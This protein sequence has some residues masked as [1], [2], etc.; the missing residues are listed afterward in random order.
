MKK[1]EKAFAIIFLAVVLFFMSSIVLRTFTRQVLVKRMEI[2]NGFTEAVLFDVSNLNNAVKS[3]VDEDGVVH[4]SGHRIID[5]AALYPFSNGIPRAKVTT[6]RSGTGKNMPS[7]VRLIEDSAEIYT[8]DFLIWY[9]KM[10]ELAQGYEKLLRWNYVPLSEYNGIVETSDGL[11]TTLTPKADVVDAAASLSTLNTF[12]Q[13]NGI[14]LLY[15]VAP[16]KICQYDDNDLSGIL[17]FANQNTNELLTVLDENSIN[18]LDLRESLHSEGIHHHDMFFITDHHWKPEAGL[19]ASRKIAEFLNTEY[20]YHFDLSLL[21]E[22]NIDVKVYQDWFL[23]SQGKKVTLSRANPEDISL[24]FPKYPT[25]F[26]YEIKSENIDENGDFSVFYNLESI[27]EKDYYKKNPY[28]AYI[29]ADQ[30]LETITNNYIDD[31]SSL[32]IIHDSFANCVVPFLALGVEKLISIDLR[33]FSGSLEQ[34]L[35]EA[36]PDTVIVMYGTGKVSGPEY[37]FR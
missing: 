14:K 5:W 8:T 16:I 20:G 6:I 2:N 10:T 15:V 36:E 28:G 37:D 25:N 7:S 26:H 3:T 24:L 31:N 12:C 19:W 18:Y 17:D 9:E 33:Y 4:T 22:E 1:S 13:G 30:P 34:F 29:Y 27:E 32:L 21:N 35:L 23:G 11:L